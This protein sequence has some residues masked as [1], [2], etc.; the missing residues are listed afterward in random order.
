MTDQIVFLP[1]ETAPHVLP[2][3]GVFDYDK[4]VFADFWAATQGPTPTRTEAEF[5]AYCRYYISD[6]R[7]L[8]CTFNTT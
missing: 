2:A 6:H 8:W 1:K 5:R 4:A 3:Q 7:P